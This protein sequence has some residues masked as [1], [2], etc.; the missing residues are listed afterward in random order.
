M[1]KY[2]AGF[3]VLVLVSLLYTY[4]NEVNNN[5]L[6]LLIKK[7]RRIGEKVWIFSSRNKEKIREKRKVVEESS[8]WSEGIIPFDFQDPL[9]DVSKVFEGIEHWETNTCLRF[10]RV[11]A[12][13]SKSA[14]IIFK[15]LKGCRSSVGRK[16]EP[17]QVVSIGETCNKVGIVV[18]EI[19]H[20]LGFY[21]E[22]R[23]SDRDDFVVINYENIL[24]EERFNFDKMDSVS[25][26]VPYDLSSI[27]HYSPLEWSENGKTTVATRD[28]MLQGIVG[29]WKVNQSLGLSHR[30]KL[31]VNIAYGCIDK[32]LAECKLES[33]HCK[34]EGYFGASCKCICPHGRTGEFCET[35]IGS[36]Y[37][38]LKSACSET[39]RYET[40]ITSPGYPFHYPNESWCTYEIVSGEK[41]LVPS[42]TILDFELG[43]RDVFDHCSFDY[44]EI[45]HENPYYG[46]V[47]CEKELRKG[48]TFK[49]LTNRMILFFKSEIGG[50]KGFKAKVTF[51]LDK[52]CCKTFKID[53]S[54]HVLSPKISGNETLPFLCSLQF[55]PEYPERL[56][57]SNIIY[58]DDE[59]VTN[60][61]SLPFPCHLEFCFSNKRCQNFCRKNRN[62]SE[63]GVTLPNSGSIHSFKSSTKMAQNV[64]L[65]FRG[66]PSSCHKILQ[67]NELNPALKINEEPLGDRNLQCEWKIVAPILSHVKLRIE[68]LRTRPFSENF[69]LIINEVGDL[70]YF[71]NVSRTYNN[72]EEIPT[73]TVSMK[74]S[75]SV[76]VDG[77]FSTELALW[78][79]IYNCSDEHEECQYWSN[80]GECLNNSEWMNTFCKKSC[81]MCE[82]SVVCDDEDFKCEYWAK[83]E[84]CSTN[85]DWMKI[86][87]A[88]SCGQCDICMNQNRDCDLWK[89]LGHCDSNLE[90]MK[91]F[92]RKSCNFCE[93]TVTEI[94]NI[95]KSVNTSLKDENEAELVNETKTENSTE[96]IFPT[97]W[98]IFKTNLEIDNSTKIL[99]WQKK[100]PAQSSRGKLDPMRFGQKKRR[101]R[102]MLKRKWNFTFSPMNNPLRNRTKN[103]IFFKRL[104]RESG[105][106]NEKKLRSLNC[107]GKAFIRHRRNKIKI[108]NLRRKNATC[109][110]RKNSFKKRVLKTMKKSFNKSTNRKRNDLN[111]FLAKKRKEKKS[112]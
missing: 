72:E 107:S 32:W 31:I 80:K 19:G 94:S 60:E 89:D 20:A 98:G 35:E 66:K 8:L 29:A 7:M 76:V 56:K 45:R 58:S 53:S 81:L 51:D 47:K 22:I 49:S 38:E 82:Y 3:V 30:D 44:L 13:N 109:F 52:N 69:N 17:G 103:L 78:F 46:V 2:F 5:G 63:L 96:E 75:L 106:L 68:K 9:P 79:E 55:N 10:T 88:K 71:P 11:N 23:R 110:M 101:K 65:V 34:G 41:C 83:N 15:K 84:E 70:S 93:E 24:E 61:T 54:I 62:E 36:Y 33:D 48:E 4:N 57:I 37:D 14:H 73:S 25:G 102:K 108:P 16:E 26:S 77:N 64:R 90:Y 43:P 100:L 42:L 111:N 92:C 12:S 39:I 21:H 18:H 86:N 6:T 27:M 59:K 112:D 91:I 74:E 85:E 99:P 28:P 87:C 105:Q 1:E 97:F 95:E 40:E 67:L 50:Q 104:Y